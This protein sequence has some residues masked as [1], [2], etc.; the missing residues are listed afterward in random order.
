[1]KYI[2]KLV[3]LAC[4]FTGCTKRTEAAGRVY[5]KYDTPVAGQ[6]ITLLDYLSSKYADESIVATT[7]ADGYYSFKFKAKRKHIYWITCR[8]DSG[9]THAKKLEGGKANQIDLKFEY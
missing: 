1:M 5:S 7:D 3:M 9:T 2:V 6:D 8:S 4:L